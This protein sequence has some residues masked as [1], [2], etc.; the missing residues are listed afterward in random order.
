MPTRREPVGTA[1]SKGEKYA[2]KRYTPHQKMVRMVRGFI[3]QPEV[4]RGHWVGPRSFTSLVGQEPH[5]KV[6][7]HGNKI[8]MGSSDRKFED[9]ARRAGMDPGKARYAFIR[10]GHT[11]PASGGKMSVQLFVS[12]QIRDFAGGFHEPISDQAL[13]RIMK[14]ATEASEQAGYHPTVK[15]DAIPRKMER[16]PSSK[17]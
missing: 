16:L 13:E 12:K 2:A 14:A 6:A 4:E 7:V 17:K 9:I 1:E 11:L 10:K 8:T 3:K 5:I 15:E